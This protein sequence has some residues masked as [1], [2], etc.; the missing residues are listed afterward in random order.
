MDKF[1]IT[2]P[3]DGDEVAIGPM[4]IQSW[5]ETY[6]PQN[7]EMTEEFIKKQISFVANE[8]GNKFRK[9]TFKEAQEHPDK[10]LYRVVKNTEGVVVGF[11]HCTKDENFNEIEGIYLLEEAKGH[12]IGKKLMED[13][14]N[15]MDNNKPSRLE[16]FG[17]NE[18]AISFYSKYGF[19]K[20]DKEVRLYK[21]KF[22]IIEMIRPAK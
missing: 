9:E 10:V 8:S 18:R 11:F 4:H 6:L 15:W 7:K 17:T 20:F 2:E 5:I 13:F 3:K 22:P 14:L 12:G 19:K 21:D 1:L 16:V